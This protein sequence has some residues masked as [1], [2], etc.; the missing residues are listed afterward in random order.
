M[1]ATGAFGDLIALGTTLV[2]WAI[3]RGEPEYGVTVLEPNGLGRAALEPH[4]FRI[5][6]QAGGGGSYAHEGE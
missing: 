6:L 5:A 1:H 2:V 3:L 4:L